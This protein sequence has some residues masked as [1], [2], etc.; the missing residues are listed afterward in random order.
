MCVCV[1]VCAF[2]RT[3]VR[4]CVCACACACACVCV[5]VCVCVFIWEIWESLH[6]TL[7]YHVFVSQSYGLSRLLLKCSAQTQE[8]LSKT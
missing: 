2:V 8:D 5:C 7:D 3:Y 4:V 1:C 6:L